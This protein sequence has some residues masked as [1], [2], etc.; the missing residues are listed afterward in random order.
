MNIVGAR[1]SA[2]PEAELPASGHRNYLIGSDRARWR[3]NVHLWSRVRVPQVLT[4]V[5][6]VYYGKGSSLEYDLALAPGL[7]PATIRIKYSGARSISINPAGDLVFHDAAG[8]LVQRK[9][10][11]YQEIAGH[12]SGK[13]P[14]SHLTPVALLNAS[15]STD[16]NCNDEGVIRLV[17]K[18]LLV[19]SV[20]F[21]SGCY[22]V[23]EIAEE[24]QFAHQ[25]PN[26]ADLIGKWVP[27]AQ[28]LKDMR[29]N[30]GYAI[31]THELVLNS[32]KSFS[33]EEYA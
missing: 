12:L 31:S 18:L 32:D 11:A 24:L 15:L 22:N 19:A 5:D 20:A 8:D 10:T 29:T 7:N 23:A 16:E 26:E 3:T 17:P 21:L 1:S 30:G 27:T 25:K 14:I 28:T 33:N 13:F 9:P 4:G 6:L 2:R